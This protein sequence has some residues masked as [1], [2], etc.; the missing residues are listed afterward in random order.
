ML[1]LR[2]RTLLHFSASSFPGPMPIK[3]NRFTSKLLMKAGKR[4][5]KALKVLSGESGIKTECSNQ[6]WI[7]FL[8]MDQI[9]HQRFQPAQLM[10]QEHLR[11]ALQLFH[12]LARQTIFVVESHM[13]AQST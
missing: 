12:R 6:V 10:V 8:E 13:F 4:L 1:Y 2:L 9:Y 11:S 3:S 5:P 7:L